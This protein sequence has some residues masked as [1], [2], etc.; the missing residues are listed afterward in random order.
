MVRFAML[1]YFYANMIATLIISEYNSSLIFY[2]SIGVDCWTAYSHILVTRSYTF[3][4]PHYICIA[5]LLTVE[6]LKESLKL[7]KHALVPNNQICTSILSG[8]SN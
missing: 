6:I 5:I 2:S 4:V 7:T 3:V 1:A 8:S